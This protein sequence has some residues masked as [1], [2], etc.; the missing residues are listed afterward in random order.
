MPKVND[1]RSIVRIFWSSPNTQP[2]EGSET[3]PD[4]RTLWA[5]TV[6]DRAYEREIVAEHAPRVK[7]GCGWCHGWSAYYPPVTRWSPERKANTR[8]RRLRA[9]LERQ[10]P[11][12]ADME[13]ADELSRRPSYFSASGIEATDRE[14]DARDRC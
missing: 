4:G 6:L 8:R 5:C 14:R 9:R 12:L 13:E 2:P 7:P 3:L 11:L 1:R 10:V